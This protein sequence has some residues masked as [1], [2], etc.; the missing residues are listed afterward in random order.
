M[1]GRCV[2]KREARMQPKWSV[3]S[4]GKELGEF[5]SRYAA[6]L[7]AERLNL[8]DGFSILRRPLRSAPRKVR[9]HRVTIRPS[10]A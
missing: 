2:P 3:I 7:F 9:G 6:M 5:A 1:A 10:A 4:R 8:K